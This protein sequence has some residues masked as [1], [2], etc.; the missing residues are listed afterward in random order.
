MMSATR[1]LKFICWDCD[2]IYREYTDYINCVQRTIRFGYVTFVLHLW[3]LCRTGRILKEPSNYFYCLYNIIIF[4]NIYESIFSA[5]LVQEVRETFFSLQLIT[6]YRYFTIIIKLK[7]N[8]CTIQFSC[9]QICL[10]LL[11]YKMI[12]KK[13]LYLISCNVM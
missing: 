6:T 11:T 8:I 13:M 3:T 1:F 5:C 7:G 2:S 10:K 4:L 12:I 9:I